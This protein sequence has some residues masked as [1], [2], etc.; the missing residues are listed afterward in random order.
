MRQNHNFFAC[1]LPLFYSCWSL[2]LSMFLFKIPF[3]TK[4]VH[5]LRIEIK[6]LTMQ[7]NKQAYSNCEIKILVPKT[8]GLRLNHMLDWLVTVMLW[9]SNMKPN[10]YKHSS[11]SF[12]MVNKLLIWNHSFGACL[13]PLFD[14]WTFNNAWVCLR[15]ISKRNI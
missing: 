9:C 14:L 4:H 2:Y 12:T 13:S 11:A 6:H 10:H 8:P 1:L 5:W 3:K 7:P 15:M